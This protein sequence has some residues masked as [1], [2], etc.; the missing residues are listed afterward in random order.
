GRI[1]ARRDAG[2]DERTSLAFGFSCDAA[3]DEPW[4][5]EAF[6]RIKGD[7]EALLRRLT[8]RRAQT[9]R[10][11]AP[12]LHPGKAA[13]LSIDGTAVATLGRIDPRAAKA[14]DL[15][16]ALY[17]CFV[18]LE[19]LPEYALPHYR[20]PSKFPGTSRDLALVL[21]AEVSARDVE[22]A[23]AAAVGELCTGVAAFDEY[24]GPQV[25]PGHK[26]LA[27]RVGLQRFDATI[28]DREADE[29]IARALAALN[30]A[31]GATV[32]T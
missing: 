3:V 13:S 4:R 19:A 10:S 27:V 28:T 9:A 26:S 6:L 31:F 17:L 11:D 15:D 1:F 24:R 8:G 2:V 12:G 16:R 20:P 14:F 5:D 18:R 30:G 22:S 23:I 25:E 29:A 21:G 7:C 32:R